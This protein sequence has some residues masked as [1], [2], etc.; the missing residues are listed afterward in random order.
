MP[1]KYTDVMIDVETTGMDA[2]QNGIL[3]I[4]AIPFN[5]TGSLSESPALVCN[6]AFYGVC[7]P[8]ARPLR[9][10]WDPKT[11]NFHIDKNTGLVDGEGDLIYS[12]SDAVEMFLEFTHFIATTC[13]HGVNFWAKP[14]H[15]DYPFVASH[16]DQL[17]RKKEYADG[18][19]YKTP[20]FH[21]RHVRDLAT[22]HSIIGKRDVEPLTEGRAHNALADAHWQLSTIC[23][24]ERISNFMITGNEK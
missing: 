20:L 16:L 14:S 3:S 10:T 1:E 19:G 23:G 7:N 22:V 17:E 2:N 18:M 8:I 5:F 11:L 24:I 15:F 21:Y 9:R 6:R 4:A 13:E 12:G